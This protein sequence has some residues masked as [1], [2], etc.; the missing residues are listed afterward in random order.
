MNGASMAV[1]AHVA[2]VPHAAAHKEG[3]CRNRMKMTAADQARVDAVDGEKRISRDR[4][5][6]EMVAPAVHPEAKGIRTPRGGRMEIPDAA[7]T[8]QPEV[9]RV[10]IIRQ[11]IRHPSE[12]V[13]VI[14]ILR[15]EYVD[16]AVGVD[17]VY[18]DIAVAVCAKVDLHLVADAVDFVL[19]PVGP[20]IDAEVVIA[21]HDRSDIGDGSAPGIGFEQRHQCQADSEDNQ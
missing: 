10:I 9:H 13:A 15:E 14:G 8:A 4:C 3:N 6:I 21:M 12:D 1:I 11:P 17:A 19:H 7:G 20:E 16:V 5:N 2:G 18:G